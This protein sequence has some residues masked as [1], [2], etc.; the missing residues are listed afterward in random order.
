MEQSEGTNDERREVFRGKTG[1]MAV[2]MLD[3]RKRWPNLTDA[4]KMV[5]EISQIHGKRWPN[6]IDPWKMVAKSATDE[7]PWEETS[8]EDEMS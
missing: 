2:M 4:R 7:R 3:R 8:G 6:L 1:S 5:A